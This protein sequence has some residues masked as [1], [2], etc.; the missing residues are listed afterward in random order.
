MLQVEKAVDKIKADIEGRKV[1]EA[2]CGRAEFSVCACKLAKE[3]CCIDLVEFRLKEDVKECENLTFERMDVTAMKYGEQTFDTVVMYNAIAHLDTVIP[4]A[5][6]ECRRVLKTGGRIHIISSF[7]IDKMV[8]EEKLIPYLK[9]TGEGYTVETDKIYTYVQ[10]E[11]G[12][13]SK[14]DFS[15]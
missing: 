13:K 4:E 11:N 10:I 1:L 12:K 3:V 15:N 2:A 9:E 14:I 7:K 5:L 6:T 8:I